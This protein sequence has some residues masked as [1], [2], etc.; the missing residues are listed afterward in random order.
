MKELHLTKK[1]FNVDWFSGTGDAA[2]KALIDEI[3]SH[4][5]RGGK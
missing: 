3:F 2:T 4:F 1:D 5:D